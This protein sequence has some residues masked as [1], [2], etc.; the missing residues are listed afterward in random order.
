MK[1]SELRRMLG[2]KLRAEERHRSK[3]DQWLVRCDDGP[4]GVVLV[5]RGDGEMNQRE[6]RI[7]ARSLGVNIAELRELVSCSMS[8]EAYCAATAS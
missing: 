7:V 2:T 8:R 1:W 5:S 6:I 4:R 3:H